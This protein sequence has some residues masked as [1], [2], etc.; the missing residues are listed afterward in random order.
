[1]TDIQKFD[2]ALKEFFETEATASAAPGLLASV[3]E[4]TRQRQP[5]P[6]LVARWGGRWL[7]DPR[8]GGASSVEMGAI[9]KAM[10][11]VALCLAIVAIGLYFTQ[12]NNTVGPV[13][14]TRSPTASPTARVFRPPT[15]GPFRPGRYWLKGPSLGD[16]S[17]GWPTRV[18]LE[19]PNGWM[20]RPGSR[21][22]GIYT[23]EYDNPFAFGPGGAALSGW[24][25]ANLYNGSDPCVATLA[26]PP[27]GPTVNDFVSGLVSFPGVEITAPA[28]VTLDGFSGKAM[29]L[30][31]PT[32]CIIK[33]RG[34]RVH[35][36]VNLWMGTRDE[37]YLES[38]DMYSYA[39]WRHHLWIL[40]VNGFR[41]VIDAAHEADASPELVAELEQMV[42]SIDIQP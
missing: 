2:R 26:D 38:F 14:P 19:I 21:G 8:V 30:V 15:S 9:W 4:V 37:Q 11:A 1:M 40:D 16:Y 32:E 36:P 17:T 25:V 27:I 13:G 7:D 22:G 41:F 24:S 10:S 39:G 31:T 34:P 29:E 23:Q 28:D 5:R 35:K 6:R 20:Q 33:I 3:I 18:T 42:D 12:Q